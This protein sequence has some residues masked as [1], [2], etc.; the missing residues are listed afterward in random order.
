MVM[1]AFESDLD[2]EQTSS[3][4]VYFNDC[5][6]GFS[7]IM[8]RWALQ[9]SE[10]KQTKTIFS[11][12]EKIHSVGFL[13]SCILFIIARQLPI[14]LQK[15]KKT[16]ICFKCPYLVKRPRA[17]FSERVLGLTLTLSSNRGRIPIL[18]P[19]MTLMGLQTHDP[20]TMSSYPLNKCCSL[21]AKTK[22]LYNF[23]IMFCTG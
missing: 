3:A 19:L 12:V 20:L 10:L 9:T 13:C 22:K 6:V 14:S 16:H 4:I 2:L 18:A 21:L 15:L 7:G 1:S 23:S 11:S 5:Q 8:N 17:G